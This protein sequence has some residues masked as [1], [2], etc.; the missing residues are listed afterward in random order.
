MNEN[1]NFNGTVLGSVGETPNMG[2]GPN[3][4]MESLEQPMPSPT[5]V[6]P[7]PMPGNGPEVGSI[8]NPSPISNGLGANPS[9]GPE[10]V[11]SV[12]P[13]GEMGPVNP[14][15]PGPVGPNPA[16]SQN[17]PPVS[18]E[19][20][21]PTP[22]A[23]EPVVPT[24]TPM[25][26]PAY[27]NPS[28]I[29]GPGSMPGFES[30]S[31]I[32]TTPPLSLEP[33]GQPPKKTN[34]TLFVVIVIVVLAAVGFGTFYVLKYTNLLNNKVAKISIVP[35]NVELEVGA[36]IPNNNSDYATITGTDIA[37]CTIDKTKIDIT[38]A[39]EYEFTITCGETHRTGKVTVLESLNVTLK[40]VVKSINETLEPSEFVENA[41][42]LTVTFV[43]E[44]EVKANLQAKGTY[45]VKLK[46]QNSAGQEKEVEGELV[47]N[48]YTVKG[49]L[50]CS[51]AP[52]SVTS[53]NAQKVTAERFAIADINGTNSNDFAD[54]AYEEVTYTYTNDVDYQN[55]KTKYQTDKTITIEDLSGEATFDDTS[56]SITFSKNVERAELET[57][58]GQDNIT[59]YSTLRSYFEGQS[60]T[61]IYRKADSIGTTN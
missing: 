39:G 6:S 48:E 18:P 11:G 4:N 53:I 23:P 7:S 14:A 10:Q 43:N 57:K 26:E 40:Q 28:N 38:K 50:V 24:P 2:M 34:K 16:S 19:P 36:E 61:C 30:S 45:P 56:K 1:N 42:G 44:E 8:P 58:Y 13:M 21:S 20:V 29:P 12:G 32:G 3:P 55:L 31:T 52:Q 22:V 41:N 5:P 60:Y 46:V 15:G 33:E 47:V 51:T 54:I 49:Y 35:K 37:S 9:V 59:K 25:P 27:T 17:V